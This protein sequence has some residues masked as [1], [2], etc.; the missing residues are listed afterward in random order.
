MISPRVLR[1]MAF[2]VAVIFMLVAGWSF[3]W[4]FSSAS[5]ACT[6]CNCSYSLFHPVPRC[7]EPYIAILLSVS[8]FAFAVGA[9]IFGWRQKRQGTGS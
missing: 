9:I 3:L 6:E 4:V 2:V 7:R 8:C 1:V 5:L